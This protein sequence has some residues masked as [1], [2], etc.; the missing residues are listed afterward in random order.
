MNCD[1]DF[2]YGGHADGIRTGHAQEAQIR[3]AFKGGPAQSAIDTFPQLDTFV[4]QNSF[5]RS[6]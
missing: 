5:K 3:R 2:G 6:A 1:D 4:A